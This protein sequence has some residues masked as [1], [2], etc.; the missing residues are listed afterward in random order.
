MTTKLRKWGNSLGV[1]IPK[2]AAEASRVAEGTAV[3]I[4]ARGGEIV[5]R[6]VK[7][8]RYRLKDLLSR[9]NKHNLHEPT[10]FGPPRGRELL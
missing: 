2:E 6:P 8:P 4:Y 3:E 5:I 1:R 10:D 9:I 7:R